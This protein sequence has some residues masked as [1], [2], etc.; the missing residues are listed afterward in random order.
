MAYVLQLLI[1]TL[2]S[3]GRMF[4]ALGFSIL[5][6][7]A[8]GIYA[9]INQKAEKAII[10]IVDILQTLPILAFFPFV[11][12]IIVATLPGYIGINAAVVFL[13]ITSMLWNIIFGVY[14]AV[15][16]LPKEFTELAELYGMSAI[17]KLKKIFVPASMPKVMEQST[18]SWA[19]GLFY[20]VTSEIFS[21]SNANYAVKHG[22]GVAL[23][24]LA[25]SGNFTEYAVGI[26]IFIIFVIATRL[27]FFAPLER[28]FNR[29]NYSN[30]KLGTIERAKRA[31]SKLSRSH[32][33]A[34][35]VHRV[36]HAPAV[37]ATVAASGTASAKR[38]FSVARIT[39]AVL[40]IAGVAALI[41]S[42]TLMHDELFVLA[43][44]A[45]SFMRVWLA[46]VVIV[47]VAV[48]ISIYLLFMTKKPGMYVLLFQVIASIPAT[49]LLPL[50][51]LSLKNA[52]LH[53]ELVAFAIFFLS[54]IWYVVF[55][56]L[57]HRAYIPQ[58]VI[59][60]KRL[61][62]VKGLL[63]WK[64]IYIYAILPGLLTGAV[65]GIAAEWNA[66]IVA[67]YFTTTAIGS[68]AV[69]TSVSLGIGRLLDTSLDSGNMLLMVLGLVNLTVMIILI[70]RFVWKRFYDKVGAVYK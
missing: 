17:D 58:S 1:D 68:G 67:E 56:I 38:R 39:Y 45:A 28:Y 63:A 54:G 26:M 30:A 5:I 61:F 16:S 3:W 31:F 23:T 34:F 40:I 59:E 2:F 43:S 55:S 22:I 44:L 20:L 51:V 70:N 11:I 13:I 33:L 65:T 50:I 66:S 12:Y 7:I 9:A 42:K 52:P 57:S 19:I 8:V 24:S 21:T 64:K 15:K 18:L 53:N 6:G 69:I 60:V 36:K 62:G 49:I 14:E 29:Y 41:A 37:H 10:P 32:M 46:F 27:L 48:P 47:A 35:H 4:V 25:V